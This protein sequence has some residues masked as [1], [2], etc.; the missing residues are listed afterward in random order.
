MTVYEKI[1]ANIIDR[2]VFDLM[3]DMFHKYLSNINITMGQTKSNNCEYV[4]FETSFTLDGRN[5]KVCGLV[6]DCGR[7]S[8]GELTCDGTMI[9]KFY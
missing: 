8:F 1:I 9:Y 7:V 4:E 6:D 3:K 2:E 5:W